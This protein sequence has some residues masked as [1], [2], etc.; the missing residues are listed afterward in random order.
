DPGLGS[1]DD[2]LSGVASF[3]LEVLLGDFVRQRCDVAFEACTCVGGSLGEL[4]DP[5]RIVLTHRSASRTARTSRLTL[6]IVSRGTGSK[7][8]ICSLK[9]KSIAAAV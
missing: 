1:L 5:R 8:R 6:L 7:S 9:R 4:C 2:V 3:A